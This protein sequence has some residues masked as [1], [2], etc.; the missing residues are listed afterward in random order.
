MRISHKHKFIFFAPPK[1][2]SSS[3]RKSLNPFSDIRSCGVV[4]SEL[5]YHVKPTKL[6]I[7]FKNQ[8]WN[9]KNYYKFAF[10][11]N[12]WSRLVSKWNY[13]VRS[14]SESGSESFRQNSI[15]FVEKNKTFGEYIRNIKSP[16]LCYS[17]IYDRSGNQLVDFV[18][19]FENL[20]EDFNQICCEIGIPKQQLPH[21]NKTKHTHYTEYYDD[22][23]IEIVAKK[24]SKDI[25][26]FNYEFGDS[27]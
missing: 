11:R 19:K 14:A 8:N 2:A 25:E 27:V 1:T 16:N 23:T 24:F 9:W 17:W 10:V 20:Q 6:K 21:A 7:Y 13:R 26:Y 22:E 12:P 3:V 4:D 5:Y 15:K 18:G